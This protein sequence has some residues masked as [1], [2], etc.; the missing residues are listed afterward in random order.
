MTCMN[1]ITF[2]TRD[3]SKLHFTPYTPTINATQVRILTELKRALEKIRRRRRK[4]NGPTSVSECQV[5]SAGVH[6]R[7]DRIYYLLLHKRI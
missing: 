1:F 7:K 2:F 3:R 5:Y 6:T 4:Q